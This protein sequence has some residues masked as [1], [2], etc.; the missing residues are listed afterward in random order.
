MINSERVRQAR[1]LAGVTQIELARAAGLNQSAI[2]H[3]EAGRF[4]PSAANLEAIAKRTGFP[5]GFFVK[6]S[7]P[8]FPIGSLQFRAHASLSARGRIRASRWAQ[9]IYE[10]VLQLSSR[11]TVL[12][13]RLPKLDTDAPTAASR[14]RETLGLA[15]NLP[16][17]NLT[18]ALERAGMLILVLPIPVDGFDAFSTWAGETPILV[19]AA[20]KPGDRLRMTVAHDV[21]HLILHHGFKGRSPEIEQDAFNFAAELLL[22]AAAM[23]RELLPPLT[24]T[25][26]AELKARWGVSIQALVRR[27]RELCLITQRQYT[28]LFEQIGARGWRT[29]EPIFIPAE[30]PRG[31]RKMIEL[32]YGVPLDYDRAAADL[33]LTP[34]MLRDIVQP[35]AAVS[36]L[37]RRRVNGRH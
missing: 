20:G 28:Y 17:E 9:T 10:V 29:D 13:V 37:P 35:Y 30:K 21:G 23:R 12:P 34:R 25:R 2:A 19:T 14:T 16:L 33:M 36:E 24:L 22:P 27:A 4:Q 26:L 15:P 1:E 32:L 7:A 3:I 31:V 5:I 11:V 18:N 8:G 6:D